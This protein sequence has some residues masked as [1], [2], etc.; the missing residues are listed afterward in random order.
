MEANKILQADVL[1]IIFEG[2]NKSYGAY[3]LRKTYNRRLTI[4]LVTTASILLLVFLGT[5]FMNF[6]NRDTGKSIDVVDTQMAEIKNDAPP[7]PP[8]PLLPPPPPHSRHDQH[9]QL[10]HR[11]QETSTSVIRR[12]T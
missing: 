3:E 11:I 9:P 6:I 8:P 10:L 12:S 4:A 7:P 5:L 2:K 1:D